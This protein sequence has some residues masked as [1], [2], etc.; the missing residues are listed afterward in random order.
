MLLQQLRQEAVGSS[1]LAAKAKAAMAAAAAAA[2]VPTGGCM[3]RR[4][5]LSDVQVFHYVLGYSRRR[6][7]AGSA[8]PATCERAAAVASCARTFSSFRTGRSDVEQHTASQ[9]RPPLP[10]RLCDGCCL[11]YSGLQAR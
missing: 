7:N 3:P 11:P 5:G 9:K 8:L 1:V 2:A 10:A 6:T 4:G